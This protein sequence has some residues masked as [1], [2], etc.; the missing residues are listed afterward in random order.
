MYERTSK[1]CEDKLRKWGT[2]LVRHFTIGVGLRWP[3]GLEC[4]FS[5]SWMWKVCGSKPGLLSLFPIINLLR[6]SYLKHRIPRNSTY[7]NVLDAGCSLLP[8]IAVYLEIHNLSNSSY[9]IEMQN[10]TDHNI[11]KVYFYPTNQMHNIIPSQEISLLVPNPN[12]KP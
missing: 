11:I 1:M 9:F 3:S 6:V 2:E 5:R 4:Q 8:H 10:E 7:N 12:L